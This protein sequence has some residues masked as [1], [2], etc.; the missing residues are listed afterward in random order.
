M[1]ADRR[2]RAAAAALARVEALIAAR[3]LPTAR[4]AFRGTLALCPGPDPRPLEHAF[5]LV[6][7]LFE[8]EARAA[9]WRAVANALAA[10]GAAEA[11]AFGPLRARLHLALGEAGPFVGA[12]RQVL[13]AGGGGRLAPY[14]AAAAGVLAGQARPGPKVFCIGLSKTGT[15]SLRAALERLGLVSAHWADPLTNTLL[16]PEHAPLY[17]G[18]CDVTVAWRFEAMRRRHPEGRFILTRRPLAAWERSFRRHYARAHGTGDPARLRA[19]LSRPDRFHWGEEWRALQTGLYFRHA[20]L[21]GAWAAHEA[22]V[23]AAFR[24]SPDALLT[25]SL[26]EGDGWPE[27]CGFLGL[28]VPDAPFPWDN[29]APELGGA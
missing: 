8:G 28:P 18:F 6:P 19:L 17:D 14:L 9:A 3:H 11:P 2:L 1:A 12:A 23:A 22:R 4:G 16:G 27:L 13:A 5:A 7:R 15:T 20:S 29:A 21:A 10:G 26:S 24:G 25:F